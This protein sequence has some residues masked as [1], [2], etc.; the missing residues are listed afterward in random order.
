[1]SRPNPKHRRSTAP[2]LVALA[3]LFAAPV[4]S[5]QSLLSTRGLGLELKPQDARA[6]ALGGVTLGM[7][8]S[9]L[10]WTNPAGAVGLPA[11]GLSLSFQLDHFSAEYAGA[12]AE[13]STARFPLLLAAFPFGE[14]WV[15]TA[16]FGSFLDQNWSLERGDSLVLDSDTVPVTD[17]LA[18]Q[19]GVGRFRVGGG[20]RLLPGLSAGLALDLFTGGVERTSGRLF[21]NETVPRCCQSRFGY[22][23]VGVAGS[24]DW[25]PAEALSL[26]VGGSLGGTLDA[27]ARDTASGGGR[28]YDLPASLSAGA[29]ARIAPELLLALS[30]DWTGWSTLDGQLADGAARDGWS[31]QGGVEWDAIRLGERVV[32][33][34]LGGRQAALPFAAPRDASE[35]WTRERA[36]TGGTGLLLGGGAA[37]VDLGVSRGWREGEAAFDESF[38]RVQFSV[39]VL[40]Q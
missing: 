17:R 10:S 34:R 29:S 6:A 18:S 12:S 13:G 39:T 2:A 9:E 11:A 16:G 4:V 35:Q 14:R 25:N 30:A 23:G 26:S 5:A 27:E 32:P 21:P 20:Y 33:I 22:S 28:S 8:G 19:G 31:V 40:G 37:S 24:V 15:V 36:I 3:V 1:M 7:P 38:W